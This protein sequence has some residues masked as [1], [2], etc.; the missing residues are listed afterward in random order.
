MQDSDILYYVTKLRKLETKGREV[1]NEVDGIRAVLKEEF[2]KRGTDEIKAGR[3]RVRRVRYDREAFDA[4]G[5]KQ[6]YP[7]TYA[8]FCKLQTVTRVE[9]VG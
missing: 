1:K 6:H 8:T 5:F 9:V 3:Y 7:D 2:E 4:K